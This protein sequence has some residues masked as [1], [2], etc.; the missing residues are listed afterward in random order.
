MDAFFA[1]VEQ[2][3]Y[4]EYRGK[5]IVVGGSSRRGV[6]AAASYEARKYGIHSAMSSVKASKLCPDV[7][8]V[9][10]RSHVYREVSRQIMDIL[11]RYSDLVQ[12]MSLDEAYVDV[13]DYANQ[14][15]VSPTAIASEIREAVRKETDLTC[16]AGISFNKFLAKIASDYKKPNG[17]FTILPSDAEEFIK[18][19]P[20]HKIPGIGKTTNEKMKAQGISTGSDLLS[21][22]VDFLQKYYGKRGRYFYHL[23]RGEYYSPISLGRGRKSLGAERTFENDLK[24]V[25]IMYHILAAISEKIGFRLQ[26][27]M[28]VGKTVTLKIKSHDF[29]IN[30]RSQTIN[31]PTNDPLVIS[32]VA[33]KLLVYP[34]PPQEPVRLLGIAVSNLSKA[35]TETGQQTMFEFS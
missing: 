29:N 6:V 27:N 21:K 5:P 26:K 11:K 9:Q 28:L 33:E 4:P 7:I 34:L 12:P 15:G 32:K 35:Y 2:R 16:S 1:A 19:L 13:G 14:F 22:G 25:K 31:Q 10:G 30:T 8:F 23:L 3:D 18:Q 20:V 24:D 17:I